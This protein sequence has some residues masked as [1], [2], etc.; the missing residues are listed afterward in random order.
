MH[1]NRW[2]SIPGFQICHF[3]GEWPLVNQIILLTF[4]SLIYEIRENLPSWAGTL[5]LVLRKHMTSI[6]WNE[7]CVSKWGVLSQEGLQCVRAYQKRDQDPFALQQGFPL[8]D[9]SVLKCQPHRLLGDTI[10]IPISPILELPQWI[11]SF[12]LKAS[13]AMWSFKGFLSQVWCGEK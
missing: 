8:Y 3:L 13:V 10:V 7:S 1:N 5:W 6:T 4:T 2:R 11:L 9:M 12:P